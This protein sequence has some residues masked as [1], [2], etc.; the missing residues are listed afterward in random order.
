[1][2]NG[3]AADPDAE[4]RRHEALIE[5][6]GGI[7][8]LLLGLGVNG[9]IAFN[10]PGS[11]RGSSTRV[12]TLAPATLAANRRFFATSEEY[13]TQAITI[14]IATILAARRIILVAVGAAKAPAARGL[15]RGEPLSSCPAA[16]LCRHPNTTVILDR[17]AAAELPEACRLR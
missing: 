1:M 16:A 11:S 7:D 10:E 17:S 9:H 15:F 3:P 14:G 12:V 4:A 13:P 8:C 6:L 2:P 5:G